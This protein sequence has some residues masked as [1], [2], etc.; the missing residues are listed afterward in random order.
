MLRCPH[1]PY[2]RRG[3]F[4]GSPITSDG[5]G[6]T[7]P[8]TDCLSLLQP[9]T[10]FSYGTAFVFGIIFLLTN[11][12]FLGRSVREHH[13]F[14][15]CPY[16]LKT[17]QPARQCQAN[18]GGEKPPLRAL[19]AGLR[20]E[21]VPCTATSPVTSSVGTGPKLLQLAMSSGCS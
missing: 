10:Y 17:A 2:S 6:V 12:I 4:L 20:P 16:S 5:T 15:L 1:F 9:Y 13:M 3:Y 11:N 18:Q 7:F 21:T 8:L 14:D 19:P